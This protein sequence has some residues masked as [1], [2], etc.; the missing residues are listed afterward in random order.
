MS[1]RRVAKNSSYVSRLDARRSSSR[2][3]DWPPHLRHDWKPRCGVERTIGWGERPREP[4]SESSGNAPSIR[5]AVGNGATARLA[6]GVRATLRKEVRRTATA[7]SAG[8]QSC[9]FADLQI[10]QAGMAQA[11]TKS[12]VANVPIEALLV[13]RPAKQRLWRAALRHGRGAGLKDR[14]RIIDWPQLSNWHWPQFQRH[15]DRTEAAA[16]RTSFC[17]H[18]FASSLAPHSAFDPSPSSTSGIRRI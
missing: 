1:L 13:W 12:A 8:L 16:S 10:R 18:Y 14:G 3:R 5:C 6:R 11:A 7:R 9:C 2:P 4:A 15:T 17:R